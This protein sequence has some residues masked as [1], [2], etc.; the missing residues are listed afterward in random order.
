MRAVIAGSRRPPAGYRPAGDQAVRVDV[1]DK[2]LRAAHESR[3][4]AGRGGFVMDPALAISTGLSEANWHR[5]VG[6]AGFRRRPARK[7]AGG[8]FGPPAP[9]TWQW[10]PPADRPR[11]EKQVP[12]PEGSA[13]AALAD[14]VR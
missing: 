3:G 10:R 14:L 4:R 9:D 1:A 2:L 8:A 6:S 13:F 12:A 11:R 5:L 7:L